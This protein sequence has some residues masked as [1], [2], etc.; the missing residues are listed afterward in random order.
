MP[1]L[2]DM[3]TRVMSFWPRPCIAGVASARPQAVTSTGQGVWA[4]LSWLETAL[5]RAAVGLAIVLVAG[6][7]IE[8]SPSAQKIPCENHS[9]L[10]YISKKRSH[11]FWVSDK[12]V[13]YKAESR[14]L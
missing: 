4:L 1:R 11:V 5:K 10:L 12:N 2:C 8:F 9:M 13:S 14:C 3:C 6:T 7:R